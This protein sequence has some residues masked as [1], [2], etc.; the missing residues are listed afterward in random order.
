MIQDKISGKNIYFVSDSGYQAHFSEI[1]NE[2]NIDIAI[3][4]VGAYE[5]HWFMS[6]A[7]TGPADALKAFKGLKAKQWIP[8]HYGTFDLSQEPIFYTEQFLK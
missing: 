6:S 8:M 2:Y 7:H 1:G 3:I 5:P 4:G